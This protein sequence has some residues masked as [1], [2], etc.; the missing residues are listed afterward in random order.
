MSN[1]YERRSTRVVDRLV[2]ALADNGV[3]HVFGVGGANIEDLFDALHRC[4]RVHS[5][6][7]KHEFSAT[8]MA[9]GYARSSGR[10]GVVA[11][12]SGGGALNLVPG[13][14]EAYASGVPLLAIVGQPPT[15]QEGLGAFQD[16]SGLAGSIDASALF[17]QVSKYT[18]RVRSAADLSGRLNEALR[19]AR[20]GGPAV[21]L[22]PKDVQESLF[23]SPATWPAVSVDSTPTASDVFGH[24]LHAIVQRVLQAPGPITVIAGDEV[25]RADARAELVKFLEVTG[26][27]VSVTPDAKDV[28]DHR[29]PAFRGIAGVMGGPDVAQSIRRSALCVVIGS[30]LPL[31]ARSGLIDALA[32]AELCS[33]GSTPPYISTSHTATD[34]LRLALRIITAAVTPTSTAARPLSLRPLAVPRSDGPGLRYRDAVGA[35]ERALPRGADVFADAGNTGAAVVHHLSL[36]DDSKF[37]VALGMGGMGYSFGAA[38]GSALARRRRTFVVA[39]DGAFYMHGLEV[40]T[41]IEYEVP[42]T[43]VLFNNN[44]HAM[45]VTREQVLLG[46]ENG[47]NR[48]RAAH[49]AAGLASMFPGLPTWFAGTLPDLQSALG[50][51][52][53]EPGP[54]VIEVLCSPDEIPP[55]TPFLTLPPPLSKGCS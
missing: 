33:I 11:A 5:V 10:I 39:G 37:V 12:T 8:T 18:A 29:H 16:S 27:D 42:V 24:G 25:A 45:C 52:S 2:D 32:D 3:D 20:Q 9:D 41:A 26:A 19:S 31:M 7:A 23:S 50:A 1:P 40:H 17:G 30:R 38:I 46:R 36:T 34:D 4:S 48:F 28:I 22:I 13:L 35:L 47:D 55:F 53:C 14:A 49:L 51:A 6:I 54:A 21:L 15:A 44:S 43:F